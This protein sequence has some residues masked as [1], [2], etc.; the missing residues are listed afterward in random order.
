MGG[1]L[2]G[3]KAIL[4]SMPVS[5]RALLTVSW[6]GLEHES[7]YGLLGVSLALLHLAPWQGDLWVPTLGKALPT[8]PSAPCPLQASGFLTRL[9]APAGAVDKLAS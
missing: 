6:E 3:S 8:V 2:V 1:E 7:A 4:R 9:S 5:L